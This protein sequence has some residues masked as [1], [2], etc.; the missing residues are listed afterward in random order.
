MSVAAA[1]ADGGPR[2]TRAVPVTVEAQLRVGTPTIIEL[3]D[4]DM[5]GV[6]GPTP[7][8]DDAGDLNLDVVVT[9]IRV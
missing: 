5:H 4:S 7:S 9:Q 3:V 2:H 1:P 6:C 8:S